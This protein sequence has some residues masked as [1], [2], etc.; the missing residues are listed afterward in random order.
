M[1][2]EIGHY[3]GPENGS[4]CPFFIAASLLCMICSGLKKKTQTNPT[5]TKQKEK[6]CC[7]RSPLRVRIHLASIQSSAEAQT[8]YFRILFSAEKNV[9]LHRSGAACNYD[10]E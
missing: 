9:L 6:A 5:S 4:L 2:A 8:T 7:R 3:S 10:P 1:W